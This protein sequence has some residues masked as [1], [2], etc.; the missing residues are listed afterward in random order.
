MTLATVHVIDV[1]ER[2]SLRPGKRGALTLSVE[3]R[4]TPQAHLVQPL[5][6]LPER[7][8]DFRV[9]VDAI[10]TPVDERCPQF[11]EL[12]ELWL[13]A[14]LVHVVLEGP[15]RVAKVGKASRVM[16]TW[17]H[18]DLVR[19]TCCGS[20]AGSVGRVDAP[21]FLRHGVLLR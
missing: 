14:G 1:D 5:L 8:R 20:P 13:E 7:P 17:L 19:S 6:G 15:H 9:H 11:H 18:D 3:G 4:L 21:E 16:D 12:E 2:D 10:R